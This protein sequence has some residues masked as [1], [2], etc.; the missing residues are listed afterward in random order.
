MDFLD[1]PNS[2][3]LVKVHA[4]RFS[5]EHPEHAE[6]IEKYVQELDRI[7]SELQSSVYARQKSTRTSLRTD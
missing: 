7:R 3:T 5:N 2:I 6:D 4:D 1:I